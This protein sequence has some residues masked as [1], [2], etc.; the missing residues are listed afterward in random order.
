MIR[1]YHVSKRY[2]D[3]AALH[4][5]S[6]KVGKGEFCY[7][8]GPS[9]A[10]KSTMLKLLYGAIRPTEGKL[11]VG[12]RDIARL[13]LHYRTCRDLLNAL[14]ELPKRFR[15]LEMDNRMVNPTPLGWRDFACL[16]VEEVR[17]Q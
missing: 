17:G 4:D 5:V 10:G 6:V 15:V 16:V 1:L 9:G 8:T 3:I 13:S 7:V 11:L 2:G 12:G 14:K